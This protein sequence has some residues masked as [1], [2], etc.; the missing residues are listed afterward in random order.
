M[1]G[2][3]PPAPR[4]RFDASRWI[5]AAT[6]YMVAGGLALA[7]ILTALG[8]VLAAVMTSS[9]GGG[10]R[11]YSASALLFGISVLCFLGYRS[12]ERTAIAA[13]IERGPA[14]ESTFTVEVVEETDALRRL[15]LGTVGGTI[16]LEEDGLHTVLR[17][18]RGSLLGVAWLGNS[19]IPRTWHPAVHFA[20]LGGAILMV[21]V[22]S[23]PRKRRHPWSEIHVAV[24]QGRRF[25][26]EFAAADDRKDLVVQVEQKDR[27]RL[28]ALLAKRTRVEVLEEPA[29]APSAGVA[30]VPRPAPPPRPAAPPPPPRTA[31]DDARLRELDEAAERLKRL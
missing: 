5:G 8:A 22:D 26:F 15:L 16:T 9:T 3:G 23:I 18:T 14:R 31:I 24:V 19:L 28:L 17:C 11:G 29:P 30:P 25:V 21:V 6:A 10:A 2:A 4:R 27:E 12:A 7:G 13:G 1:D 20:I